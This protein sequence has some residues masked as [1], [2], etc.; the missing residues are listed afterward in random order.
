MRLNIGDVEVRVVRLY[1]DPPIAH[2]VIPYFAFCS[3]VNV[4]YWGLSS[5]GYCW[6]SLNGV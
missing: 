1:N 2:C 3:V 4:Q 6:R 5:N